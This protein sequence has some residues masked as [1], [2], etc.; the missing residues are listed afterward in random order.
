VKNV[1]FLTV[2][3]V[4]V[5]VALFWLFQRQM[6]YL[7]SGDATT[8]AAAGLPRAEAVTFR[9]DD[10]LMLGGWF[11]PAAR[12]GQDTV[13]VFN[14]NAGN[15]SYRADIAS[16]FAESGLSV[17]L[18]DYRGYGGNPGSP[19]E[20]GLA[21]DARAARRYLQSRP[22]IDPQRI[23][24][25]GESLGAAVAVRLAS[26]IPPRALILRSPF[27]SVLDMARQHYRPLAWRALVRDRFPS[28]D[29]IPRVGCP[30]LVIAG[31]A[32]T[33]VPTEQSRRLFDAAREPKKL[34]ILE[35]ADHNDDVLVAGPRVISGVTRFLGE[36]DQR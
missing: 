8:P 24:Y 9:T 2:I 27:T 19:S 18:F 29:L 30:V 31:T 28:I 11:V 26:E 25:F 35:G 21:L 15:R 3:V 5:I 7:P 22:D 10:G 36:L 34:L 1:L 12:P 33:I 17:L 6:L 16:R 13:I 23:V 14:G 4:A 32:D 20:E